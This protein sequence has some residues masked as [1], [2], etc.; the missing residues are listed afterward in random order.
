MNPLFRKPHAIALTFVLIASLGA[1]VV[2]A[3]DTRAGAEPLIRTA[4]YESCL[5]TLTGDAK[6]YRSHIVRRTIELY[7]LVFEGFKEVPDYA[8]ILKD[9]NLD[10]VEKFI[11]A[12]F[13]AGAAQWVNLSKDEV[14]QRAR[15]QS[16]G[17]LTFLSDQEAILEFGGSTM[18]IVFEDKAWKIDE[19]EDGKKMFLDNF[20]LTGATRAKIEKL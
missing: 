14:E 3:Q 12:S 9:N 19:T 6:L 17:K 18:R 8:A 11:D 13:K 10:T 2:R 5:A 1:H 15:A 4:V 16:N 20:H 7:R